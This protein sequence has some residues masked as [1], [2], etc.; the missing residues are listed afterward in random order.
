MKKKLLDTIIIGFALFAIFFG[1]GNL[2]FPPYL[3]VTA[4]ENW[5]IATL[6]FLISDP[7]LSIIAVMVVAAL[8]GSALN[9]GRR[10]HPLFASAL[11]AI[12][13]LLIGPIFAVPRTGA[14][15]HEIF[16]Q[17]YFPSAPQWITSLVFFGIVLWITYKENS[18]MDAIGKY[19]TPILL[20]ILF[21]IFVGAVLQP[22][23]S[24]AATDRTGLFA[25]GFKE[26]YQ[27]MD[28]LGAPL[29]A[30]VVMKDI[31]R[32]G[33]LNK[34]DQFRMMFGVGIVA[35]ILLALV[36]STLAY[37]GAS[38]S[39]VIDTTAQRA[40]MLTTI[41]KNL[42]GSWGQLAMGLAVCF[43]CLT[44]AIGLTTTCGQYF[45]EVSKGKISYKKTILVTVAVEF[46]ISLVGVDSLINLAVPVLTFIFPIM[47]ALIL[48]SAFDKY[49]P[50]DWTYLG[51]VV[52]A[53]IVGL[54]QGINT[55]SQLLGGNLLGDA[56][57]LIGTFPL[58]TY[59]LEWI[60]PT[61][62]GALIFTILAAILKP[63][64]L[65]FD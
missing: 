28:V 53:G 63:K 48:F 29:L 41:V 39:T 56:V 35:F 31:T 2:I 38:M 47:I 40:A 19:L 33:Y 25:Q 60:V 26:G 21:L 10:I 11:A 42:L 57:K 6:A 14:S 34:K 20:L 16:V 59:G 5:G 32:R 64:Q 9:V 36:Y 61:F 55:L 12:C 24:F 45:E 15:T 23:A 44:T 50:Y 4:G 62:V 8:G 13:V 7:L 51:A 37:S 54:V 3:G 17:S 1:A 22:N 58:A 30:G 18:V 27:T 43:A 52:G 49:V 65:E 46:I